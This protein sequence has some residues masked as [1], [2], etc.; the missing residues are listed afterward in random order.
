MRYQ[1][2]FLISFLLIIFTGCAVKKHKNIPYLQKTYSL[3]EVKPTL[4]VFTARNPKI[5][6]SPVLIFVHGGDWNSGKKEIYGFF[7]RNFAKK[8]VVS[9]IPGYTLSP[10]VNYDTMT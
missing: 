10:K 1:I 5:K 3:N 9:V 2:S 8:G 7:G 4:N 6:K